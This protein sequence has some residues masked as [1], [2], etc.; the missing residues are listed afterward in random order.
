MSGK[1]FRLLGTGYRTH[2]HKNTYPAVEPNILMF[3]I[4]HSGALSDKVIVADLLDSPL[5]RVRRY[6]KQANDAFTKG[7]ACRDIS[8]RTVYVRMA[9]SWNQLADWIETEIQEHRPEQ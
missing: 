8:E 1:S 5:E 4:R 2:S 9:E 7:R 6:R 3:V